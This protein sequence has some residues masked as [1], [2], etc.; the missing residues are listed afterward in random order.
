MALLLFAGNVKTKALRKLGEFGVEHL[1]GDGKDQVAALL[2]EHTAQ[3][4]QIADL[5]K[6][7]VSGDGVS[8]IDAGAVGALGYR[9][10]GETIYTAATDARQV[11]SVDSASGAILA[12]LPV[13]IRPARFCVD[14]SGGQVFVTGADSD[15]QLV[16]FS[17]YQNQV[18]QTLY[19]GHA[20]FGMAV[21]PV[22]KLLF[23]SDPD[24]GEVTI[25]W[26]DT[27]H[28][29]ASIRTGGKPG[30]ILI[31]SAPD[32]GPEEYAFVVDG[33]SGDVSVIHIPVVLHKPGDAF[34]SEPPK[35]VFAV[36]HG[37][38]DPQSAV[39]IPYTS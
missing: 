6:I 14:G 1:A 8:E 11:I 12:R 36:F 39:I 23:L 20:L 30:E 9:K 19:A 5:V 29:A 3:H 18:D 27:R 4:Q 15:P 24:A 2:G 7:G 10:D 33:D 22:R 17:P 21:A 26:I 38:A 13:P 16:I 37:G 34:I 35:P 31:A 32:G 28:M 25:L